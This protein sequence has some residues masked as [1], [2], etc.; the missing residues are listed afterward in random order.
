[1]NS[2]TQDDNEAQKKY[3][4]YK[5]LDP[6]PE[7][8]PALLN[9]AD[10]IDYVV[11]TGLICPFDIIDKKN[12]KPASIALKLLGKYVYWDEY[13]KKV[14]G[15]IEEGKEFILKQNTIAFVSLKEH[16][17]LPYYIAARFNLKIDNIYRGLLLGTGPLIDPGFDAIL[18]FPLHNL[19]KN[20]Y[21]FIGGERIIWMEF[22]KL[23]VNQLWDKNDNSENHIRQGKYYIPINKHKYHNVQD[24]L[25]EAEK[26]R[27]VRSTLPD[28]IGEVKIFKKDINSILE[29]FMEDIHKKVTRIKNIQYVYTIATIIGVSALIISVWSYQHA[30][31]NGVEST[32]R[33]YYERISGELDSKIENENHAKQYLQMDEKI[34]ELE[35]QL[36]ELDKKKIIDLPVSKNKYPIKRK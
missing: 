32:I 9:N 15:T 4:K 2:I 20:D 13:G 10:I 12:I 7:I 6:F 28:I 21:V 17:R 27:D 33:V 16:I 30:L 3:E 34:K 14:N 36:S 11:A 1:M 31:I 35:K 19:T 25:N 26:Q 23:S 8:K 24:Y 18:S 29:L 22:T 5:S